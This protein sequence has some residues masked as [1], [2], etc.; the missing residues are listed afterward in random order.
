MLS[1]VVVGWL[2]ASKR[3]SAS[4]VG[5]RPSEGTVLPKEAREAR[6]MGQYHRHLPFTAHA[7]AG[8]RLIDSCEGNFKSSGFRL[9]VWGTL[10][11][12]PTQNY[13]KKKIKRIIK[14]HDPKTLESTSAYGRQ[15]GNPRSVNGPPDNRPGRLPQLAARLARGGGRVPQGG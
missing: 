9:N 3:L 14:F 11:T 10:K 1:R 15:D 2:A 8:H 13:S 6:I 5:P 7:P 4:T 12:R